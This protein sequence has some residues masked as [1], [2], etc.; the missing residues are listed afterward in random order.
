VAPPETVR[1]GRP[2]ANLAAV[3]TFSARRTIMTGRRGRAA[4]LACALACTGGTAFAAAP[5]TKVAE[6]ERS[7][8]GKFQ[9]MGA[10]EAR[11]KA[12]AW[13]R[14]AGKSGPAVEQAL[15]AI[16]AK[17]RTVLDKVAESLALGDAEAARLLAEARGAGAAPTAVPALLKDARQPAFFRANLA[18]AYAKALAQRRVYEEA[19]EVLAAV[20]PEDV[21]DPSAYF[22]HKAVCEHALMLKEDALRSVDRLLADVQDAPERHREVAALMNADMQTWSEKDLGWVARKMENIRRRLDLGRGGAQTR[23][24]QRAVLAALQKMIDDLENRPPGPPGPDGPGGPPGPDGP[25][26][27]RTGRGGRPATDSFPGQASGDGKVG[28]RRPNFR[29]IDW[30]KLPPKERATVMAELTRGLS[31]KDRAVVEAYFRTLEGGGRRGR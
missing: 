6:R 19:L 4:L 21:V 11:A 14:S 27:P 26:G 10:D 20:R 2:E 7:A 9:G 31:A 17:D 1:A 5:P 3:N 22:F 30:G 23:R 25:S 12:R 29:T 15:E 18:L 16:W 8:F 28:P 13:L 24:Q